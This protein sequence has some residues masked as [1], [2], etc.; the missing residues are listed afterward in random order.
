M[1]HNFF[2]LVLITTIFFS[3]SY[4][5]AVG[6]Y[7]IFPYKQIL[8]FTELVLYDR[9]ETNERNR[10][11]RIKIYEKFS[12]P[13]DSVFIGDSITEYGEWNDFFSSKNLSNRGVAG[14]TTED[15]LRRLD[16]IIS[17]KAN[18]IDISSRT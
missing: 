9:N 17:T 5:L 1:N 6:A 4:G 12:P 11:Y 14:D 2:Y 7:K 3:F 8:A 15:I 13:V 10:E 16:S 18:S